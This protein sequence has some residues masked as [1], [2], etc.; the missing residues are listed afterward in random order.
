MEFCPGCGTVLLP[1]QNK[2]LIYC[3][4]FEEDILI[5]TSKKEL[6]EYKSHVRSKN[7]K[8]DI[9]TLKTAIINENVSKN[10]SKKDCSEEDRETYED[11]FI[12]INESGNED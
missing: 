4:V 11:L 12:H 2:I 10:Y 6:K 8:I 7:K 1:K 5:M 9:N 3:R